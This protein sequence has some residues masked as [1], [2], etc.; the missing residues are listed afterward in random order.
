M[1]LNELEYNARSN[2]AEMWKALK[3]LNSPPTT[4]A[5]LEI[6]RNDGTISTDVKEVLERWL[7]D[8]SRLFS[9]LQ[10]D[11]EVAFDEAFY[12]EVLEKKREFENLAENHQPD[13]E[14]NDST[15]INEEITYDE[16]SEAIDRSK[17]RKSYLEIPNEAL[18]NKH[19]KLLLH[20]FFNLCFISG[21]NPTDW[22]FSDIIPI[23]KKDKDARDPLQNRCITIVC[24]VAF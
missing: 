18:K 16:V 10:E 9:G 14:D 17:M 24:C 11:P 20:K 4:K 13:S 15:S 2:P 8:I 19:S 1:Q 6:V 5:A 3:R 22:D 21:Y 23:P 7:A 12:N